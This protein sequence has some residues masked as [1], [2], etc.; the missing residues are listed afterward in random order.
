M[1]FL[2]SLGCV[3]PVEPEFDFES[4]V[5]FVEGLISNDPKTSIVRVSQNSMGG[6]E[7]I[8]NA[9]V[10]VR[11]TD[12]NVVTGLFEANDRYLLPEDFTAA[13]G[14]T[15]EL[16]VTLPDG[17]QYQSLP[18]EIRDSVPILDIE[19]RYDPELVFREASESFVPGHTLHVSFEDPEEGNNYY[20]WRFTS[21]ENLSFCQRCFNGIFRNGACQ[22]NSPSESEIRKSFYTY[23]CETS[24][25]RIR[26]NESVETFA[27]EFSNGSLIERLPVG[28]V[29]L[30][31]KEDILVQL[32]QYALSESAYRY[33]QILKDIVD[34][35]GGFNAPP[36]AALIG[37]MFAVHDE[38]EFVIGRFTATSVV[39]RYLFIDRTTISESQ[40]E[41][42]IM[43][44]NEEFGEVPLPTRKTA[45]CEELPNRT[46]VR[47]TGWIN[48]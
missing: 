45:P 16:T 12:T 31:T 8:P 9:T 24:C 13:V 39:S 15:F 11:N 48:N 46:G 5:I 4:G 40:I 6:N 1:G 19:A 32:Q 30:Y 3:E 41:E 20:F 33:Y 43:V 27:D 25:W 21:F 44:Q 42:R 22:N 29:L 18:E 38:N 7:F 10:S 47:P 17:R 23:R 28:N 36:P 37:N 26:F 34:N 35:N 2:F 14:D